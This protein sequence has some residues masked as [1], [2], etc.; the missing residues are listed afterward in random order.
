M[1]SIVTASAIISILVV[2]PLAY[3]MAD[4]Q[5]PYEYDA[6]NSY[7]IP[8]QSRVDHQVVVHWQ[9]KRVNRVCPGSV[10]RVIVDARSG[11]QTTFDPTAVAASVT[12]KSTHL[13][14]TFTLP[15]NLA[16]GP[17]LYRAH[18]AFRCNMLQHFWPLMVR[19]PD[20]SFE[21]LP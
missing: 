11:A 2:A 3:M 5:P 10:T 7:I 20:L 17:Q 12:T 18:V 4:N 16:P 19:T 14:R 6:S 15:P 13:D 21:V 9:F 8:Q 1:R